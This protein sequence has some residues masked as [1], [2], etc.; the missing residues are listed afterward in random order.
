MSAPDPQGESASAALIGQIRAAIDA[1]GGAISFARFMGLALYAPVH[2]YYQTGSPKLGPPG[3]FTTAPE[4][5]RLFAHCLARQCQQVLTT[6]G[7]GDI[8][9][10]GAGSGVLAAA[11]LRELEH[12]RCLPQ[13]YLIRE[14]SSEMRRRQRALISAQAP[15]LLER[16]IWLDTLAG[17]PF[18]GAIVANEVLD[19]MPVQCFRLA[20]GEVRERCVTWQGARF[21]WCERAADTSLSAAI[22]AIQADLPAPLPNG[23]CSEFNPAITDWIAQLGALL[24]RGVVLL[25]D[26]GYPRREYYLPERATGT[27][28]CHYRHGVHDNPLMFA[29]LQDLTAHVDFTAVA[30]AASAAGLAVAGFTPQTYFLFGNG[31]MELAG[32]SDPQA[33][34]S[35][36]ALTQQIKTLSL[37]GAMGERFKVLALTRDFAAPLNGFMLRDL[38][39][40]L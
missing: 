29:G 25:I 2:G 18:T 8:L 14:I 4:A 12:L 33:L 19:A 38:R 13:R 9:E 11:L 7:G 5:T 3:D 32:A 30:R 16:V 39:D 36:L 23:Y 15:H 6:L 28:L 37:P 21:V 17:P 20:N 24:T 27:L 10:F 26:Y 40:R 35:H 1:A 22:A 34:R 31:L